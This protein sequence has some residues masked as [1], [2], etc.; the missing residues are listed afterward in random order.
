MNPSTWAEK[1]LT[2]F[3]SCSGFSSELPRKTQKSS[4]SASVCAARIS[5]GKNGLATSGT[6]SATLP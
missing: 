2:S 5:G 4:F 3:S 6:T 1:R